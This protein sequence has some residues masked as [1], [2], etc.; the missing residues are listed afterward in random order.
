MK[1]DDLL[2]GRSGRALISTDQKKRGQQL[3]LLEKV[4]CLAKDCKELIQP[5]LPL[6][7]L[8][9]LQSMAGKI[10][11]L[12]L[13]DNLGN[14]VF[15]ATTKRLDFPST[16]P[17]SR[18]PR[19]NMKKG[20]ALMTFVPGL[21]K[22]SHEER[23]QLFLNRLEGAEK[24]IADAVLLGTHEPIGIHTYV[25]SSFDGVQDR[26]GL[27]GLI[28]SPVVESS[29]DLV[30]HPDDVSR[31]NLTLSIDKVNLL[32]MDKLNNSVDVHQKPTLN[33][34]LNGTS[35]KYLNMV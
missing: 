19:K 32:Q 2:D 17:Q 4:L 34:T 5:Y 27:L 22:V 30:Q 10:T 18:F 23:L 13:R 11:T 8:C 15:N 12:A 26:G 31:H 28:S 6:C 7:K 14:A 33:G 16:V 20:K 9:Y 21:A 3:A 1:A 24:Q 25:D 35:L 29:N